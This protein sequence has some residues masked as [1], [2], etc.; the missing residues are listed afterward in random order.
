MLV[1]LVAA[2]YVVLLE[3]SWPLVTGQDYLPV[4]PAAAILAAAG[5][6]RW[7]RSSAERPG[8]GAALC[9]APAIA[10]LGIL[11]VESGVIALKGPVWRDRTVPQRRLVADVLRL[12]ERDE[13]VMDAKGESIF[14]R[15]P[16]SGVLETITIE[17]LRRGLVLDT[18][19]DDVVRTRC[20]V[21]A[22]D[23]ARFPQGGRA[24]LNE[25][26]IS[27]GN[28]RV[29]GQLVPQTG[30]A[31]SRSFA[32]AIPGPYAMVTPEGAAAG[33]LDGVPYSGP[34]ELPA[35]VH[36]VVP[37]HGSSP[38]AVVWARAVERGY[39]PFNPDRERS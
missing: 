6:D 26:F 17:K 11:A 27:V 2:L 16:F 32:I 35:G 36:E 34:R 1:P 31:A 30:G 12:T 37:A 20:F 22:G 3:S 33:T 13:P 38:L 9:R 10:L 4:F 15:R 18:I 23:S 7:G 29:A 21:A 39:S 19:A 5:L 8:T 24:F 25:N 28:L 14:R